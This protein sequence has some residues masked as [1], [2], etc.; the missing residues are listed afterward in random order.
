MDLR[1]LRYFVGIVECGSLT[2]ASRRLCIA[3]PALSQQVSKLETEVGRTLLH[4]SAKGVTPTENG[5]ALYHHARVMLRQLEQALS[6]ARQDGGKVQGVVSLGLPAT[7]LHALGLPLVRQIRRKYP[8]ILLNVVEGLS[9][10]IGQMMRIGQLDLAVLFALDA[11]PD[12]EAVELFEEELFVFLPEGSALVDASRDSLSLRE[13]AGLPLILPTG[14]HGL[15]RRV[16]AE[17]ERRGLVPNVVAEIDSVALTMECVCD[18]IGATIKPMP[19]MTPGA[20]E[21][22]RWRALPIGDARLTR[23]NY[24]YS[25]TTCMPSQP[26]VVV[27]H[28]L[29]DVTAALVGSGQWPG[30]TMLP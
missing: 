3:Q 14:S 20:Q 5:L 13:V 21:R 16:C 9:G 4:R 23:R 26:Q 24:L 1:Q 8:G 19:A 18:A 7:T 10:Q 12:F 25:A 29:R 28:E 15:R 30:V 6:V 2:R 22:R 27:A 17:F 11:L